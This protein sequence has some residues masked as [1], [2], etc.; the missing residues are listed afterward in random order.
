M[1]LG[2]HKLRVCVC[3]YKIIKEVKSALAITW[4]TVRLVFGKKTCMHLCVCEILYTQS[5]WKDQSNFKSVQ[6]SGWT[7]IAPN[8]DTDIP[9][10]KCLW[11]YFF[12]LLRDDSLLLPR[13]HFFNALQENKA[14]FQILI[15]I[16]LL[17]SFSVTPLKWSFNFLVPCNPFPISS[18]HAS[19]KLLKV[20]VPLPEGDVSPAGYCYPGKTSLHMIFLAVLL[21]PS[22]RTWDCS[23]LTAGVDDPRDEQECAAWSAW[24]PQQAFRGTLICPVERLRTTHYARA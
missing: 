10:Q 17:W 3:V 11:E 7:S 12:F 1:S 18:N 21:P 22:K 23:L 16:P 19:Q 15:K 5:T 9:C 6:P 20:A 2:E 13:P 14:W 8:S 24:Q 4:Q